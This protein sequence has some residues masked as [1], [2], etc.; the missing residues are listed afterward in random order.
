MPWH[1]GGKTVL[2]NLQM[3]GRDCNLKMSGQE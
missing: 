3:L 2:E 1:A